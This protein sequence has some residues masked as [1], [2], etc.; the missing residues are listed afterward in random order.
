MKFEKK[1]KY[2][3]K[4]I[5]LDFGNWDKFDSEQD[6]LSFSKKWFS[7]CI[8]VLRK[9]GHFLSFWDKH[10]LT[11]FRDWALELNCKVRQC[12]WWI[13]TNPVP[14]ARKVSFM[15]A[16][17][18]IFWDYFMHCIPGH[19]SKSDGDRVHPCQKPTKLLQWIISYLSNQDDIILDPFIGSGSTAIACIRLKKKFY[20]NRER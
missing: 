18:C 6:Y 16:V 20:W 2:E 3:G 17:E 5:D 15:S 4:D 19:T 13:K 9:G 11:F 10:K 12:L 1:W 14:Q 8:R 7:E